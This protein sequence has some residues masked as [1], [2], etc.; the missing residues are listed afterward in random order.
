[1]LFNATSNL[2]P[3]HK[4]TRHAFLN[5]DTFCF[6][7]GQYSRL[8]ELPYTPGGDAAGFVHAVG[9][10]VADLKVGQRVFATGRNTGSYAEFLVR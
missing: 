7:E 10:A 2:P 5:H 8:P 4:T 1:M 3:Q 9:S 6:R